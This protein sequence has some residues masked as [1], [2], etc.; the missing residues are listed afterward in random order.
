[1]R[2][3]KPFLPISQQIALLEERGLEIGDGQLATR[4]LE[5][6]G[7]Y[8]LSAYWYLFREIEQGNRTDT[9]LAGA[10]LQDAVSLYIFDK[11]LRLLVLDAIER[12]EIS[13]RTDIALTIGVNGGW[14]HRDAQFVHTRFNRPNR[15]GLIPFQEWMSRLDNCESRSRDEFVTH[16][17]T[18]YTGERF[19]PIWMSVEVWELGLLSHFLGG[20][21]HGD[22]TAISQRYGLPDVKLL[23]SWTRTFTFVRNVCAHHGRLW[24]RPMVDQPAFPR[25]GAIATFD[26]VAASRSAQERLYGTLVILNYLVRQLNGGTEWHLRVKEL[27]TGF[28]DS[29]L[30]SLSSAGFP[31]G[32]ER[33]GIWS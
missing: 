5:Q 13:L 9:F 29:A 24:N 7:Y 20:L 4:A 27:L 31:T 10:R 6:I 3:Q 22:I 25:A 14:A 21:R 17:R 23:P 1:M 28:P 32:W 16:F 15:R 8:R 2:Y 12:I 19:L 18:K 30:L 11:K 33:E 26:H